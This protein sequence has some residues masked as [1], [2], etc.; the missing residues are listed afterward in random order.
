MNIGSAGLG[1]HGDWKVE[2]TDIIDRGIYNIFISNGRVSL[3]LVGLSFSRVR[4]IA[5]VIAE[6]SDGVRH[7]EDAFGG[8]LEFVDYQKRLVLRVIH[9]AGDVGA[10]LVEIFLEREERLNLAIAL[11][12]AIEDAT[13]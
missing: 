10:N 13:S 5:G 12:E 11:K 9:E 8:T 4:L 7:M 1:I 6:E 2:L 3:R